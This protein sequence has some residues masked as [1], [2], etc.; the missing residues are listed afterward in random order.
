VFVLPDE[1]SFDAGVFVEPLACVIR[2]QRTANL[3]PGQAVLILGSGISGLL[4]LLLAKSLGA[5]HIAVTDISEFRL[6][7]AR[8]LGADGL[9]SPVRIFRRACAK[10]MTTGWPT[11]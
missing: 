1:V 7:M 2:G 3:Q 4:H 9:F 5:G 6:G 8:D 10:S 11:S